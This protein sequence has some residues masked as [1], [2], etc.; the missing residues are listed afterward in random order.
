MPSVQT[1][2]ITLDKIPD[3]I[4]SPYQIEATMLRLDRIHPVISGNKWFKLRFHLEQA[5]QQSKKRIVTWGGAWSN[6]IVATAAACTEKGI[7]S[8]GLIRGEKPQELS[9]TLKEAGELGMQFHFL[10]REDYRNKTI[11]PR[12]LNNEDWI[13]PEGGYGKLG[14]MG[15]ASITEYFDT[16]KYTHIICAVGTG[17]MMAGLI[18]A[19][20]DTQNIIGIPVLKGAEAL[21][22]AIRDLVNPNY[23]KWKLEEGY[24]FGGYA[25]HPEELIQ[26]MNEFYAISRIPTDIVYTG[27]LVYAFTALMKTHYF[28]TNS[29]ILIVHSGGL[30]GN[31][32]LGKG[33]V[34]FNEN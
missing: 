34:S 7:P 24:E 10:S 29:R 5:L 17:T 18:N 4:T 20:A 14:A 28:P 8:L 6:H 11:P 13:I 19:M 9:A 3:C 27:K 15:A 31:R 30:Q 21:R 12:V 16:R 2:L 32:S 26:F 23:Q 25:K 22:T 1:D 33:I